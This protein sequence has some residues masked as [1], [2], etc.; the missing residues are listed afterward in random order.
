MIKLPVSLPKIQL[1]AWPQ[2]PVP[3]QLHNKWVRRIAISLVVLLFFLGTLA[4]LLLTY[5]GDASSL[6]NASRNTGIGTPFEATNTS[7]R[8]ALTE[9]IVENQSFELTEA[10]ARF[11]A[12]DL[13]YVNGKF[14]SIFTP[15]ISFLAIP[16]YMLGKYWTTPEFTTF[17]LNILLALFN[18]LLIIRL[19]RTLTNSWTASLF[20][21]LTFLFATNAH[22]YALTLTQHH[23]AILVV[24][25]GIFAALRKPGWLN[26]IWFGILCGVGLLFDFPNLF[27]LLPIGLHMVGNYVPLTKS[28]EKVTVNFKLSIISIAIGLLP[29]L[30]LYGWYNQ[31]TVGSPTGVAQFVGRTDYFDSAE[32]K[33]ER[34][35]RH[36]NY[37]EWQ[38]SLPFSTRLQLQG[39]HILLTSDERSWLYYSP[40]VLLGFLGLWYGSRNPE[41]KTVTYLSVF[42]LLM[43]LLVYISV[44]DPW[45]GWSFGPRYLLPGAALLSIF[46]GVLVARWQRFL[47][48]LLL[49]G[50]LLSTSVWISSMGALTSAHIPPKQETIALGNDL[51]YTWALNQ[52]LLSQNKSS[53]FAFNVWLH[54]YL[55]VA[56]LHQKL[57]TAITV[58]GWILL[59]ATFIR[60]LFVSNMRS[61]TRKRT[62]QDKRR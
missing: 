45:G 16:W 4:I 61:V 27:L 12:P 13:I 32:Q 28:G 58:T 41:Q 54:D 26:G 10:Q 5:K 23:G 14:F 31:L 51:P 30:A 60:T 50:Y 53:S 55:T 18:V 48:G 43:N 25:L 6:D 49:V 8:F 3:A 1:P 19:V 37:D 44:G 59:S 36:A 9:A 17:G 11:S 38:S 7:S 15:G 56:E 29:L 22:A 33:A 52:R 39:T 34:E 57:A 20:A 42:I 2:I 40:I 46:V 35:L 24:L 47:P 62:T 21:A